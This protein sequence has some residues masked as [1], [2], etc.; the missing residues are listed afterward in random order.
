L[1][2]FLWVAPAQCSIDAGD[3][4]DVASN[5]NTGGCFGNRTPVALPAPSTD[6]GDIT[7]D[8]D[9]SALL[10]V[11]LPI[12]T[13]V[14]TWSGGGAEDLIAVT[15]VA[16]PPPAPYDLEQSFGGEV[17]ANG[18]YINGD[19][20]SLGARVHSPAGRGFFLEFEVVP[21]SSAFSHPQSLDPDA[22]Q[23]FR[24]ASSIAAAPQSLSVTMK[25]PYGAYR[26]AVRGLDQLGLAGPWILYDNIAPNFRFN[27]APVLT[28]GTMTVEQA[29]PAGTVVTIPCVCRD[30]NTASDALQIRYAHPFGT[31]NPGLYGA[32]TH[33][34]QVSC[35]DAHGSVTRIDSVVIV[36][37]TI[38]PTI[39]TVAM[40]APVECDTVGGRRADTLALTLPVVGDAADAD[41]TVTDDRPGVVLLGTSTL[42]QTVTD[43]GGNSASATLAVQVVD[44]EPPSLRAGDPMEVA[45]TYDC[46]AFH[47]RITLPMPEVTDVCDA[48]PQLRQ[49]VDG[50]DAP[51]V[52]LGDGAHTVTWTAVDAS[53]NAVTAQVA[54][55]VAAMNRPLPPADLKQLHDG[56][57]V[58]PGGHVPVYAIDLA[59]G[60]R[61]P[62][63]AT[64]YLLQV[65]VRTLD[66]PL[67]RPVSLQVDQRVYFESV[68]SDDDLPRALG[69]HVSGLP[70]GAYH[71]AVRAVDERGQVTDWVEFGDLGADFVIDSAAQNDPPVVACQDVTAAWPE[72]VGATVLLSCSCSDDW[73]PAP[74]LSFDNGNNNANP[75]LYP[76]GVTMVWVSCTDG[77]GR[78]GNT[79]AAVLVRDETPPSVEAGAD[80]GPVEC[81]GMRT[82]V[83]PNSPMVHDVIDRAPTYRFDA[84][85]DF[86]LGATTVTVT[87]TD[88]AGNKA[89]DTFQVH[90]ADRTAPIVAPGE[91][92]WVASAPGT[93]DCPAGKTP[94]LLATPVVADLCDG[95]PIIVNDQSASSNPSLC[96]PDGH[97]TVTWTATDHSG[98]NRSVAV[99]AT[100]RTPTLG[101]AVVPGESTTG[102]AEDL[103]RYRAAVV[104]PVPGVY[105]WSVEGASAERCLNE[106]CSSFV[107]EFAAEGIYCPWPVTVTKGTEY[108]REILC[109]GV[110]ATAP[111]LTLPAVRRTPLGPG[112]DV[113]F[114]S[115]DATSG[116]KS[117]VVQLLADTP[118]E[119]LRLAP[120]PETTG[121]LKR[122]PLVLERSGC[123]HP[124]LCAGG[125][126]QTFSLPATDV[127]LEIAVTDFAGNV[128]VGGAGFSLVDF[129]AGL[130]AVSAAA[131]QLLCA[132]PALVSATRSGCQ[133]PVVECAPQACALAPG[134]AYKDTLAAQ[135]RIDQARRLW[136]DD[137]P[138]A[139]LLAAEGEAS[140]G[141]ALGEGAPVEALLTE[142]QGL[143]AAEASRWRAMMRHHHG[144]AKWHLAG[145][146]ITAESATGLLWT[147][148]VRTA[149]TGDGVRVLE[150]PGCAG[151]AEDVFGSP[152]ACLVQ[153]VYGMLRR[154]ESEPYWA[155]GPKQ[156]LGSLTAT[157]AS[158]SLGIDDSALADRREWMERALLPAMAAYAQLRDLRYATDAAKLGLGAALVTL[159]E[160]LAPRRC[161]LTDFADALSAGRT[162]PV[163]ALRCAA[164]NAYNV[165]GACIDA[166][167]YGCSSAC[168]ASAVSCE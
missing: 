88:A 120:T 125:L 72:P 19:E 110:D 157:L 109:F 128:T 165:G 28:C 144:D 57:P 160:A 1:A 47:S 159:A 42:L 69:A 113:G 104:E 111:A 26:W 164:L 91:G 84:P 38:A 140:L 162:P 145:V 129:Y 6:C 122:G 75:D 40:S 71:W 107:A 45:A 97:T 41:L 114:A 44:T 77:H 85:A 34:A 93:G 81:T 33:T 66:D 87:A 16:A 149:L 83:V 64:R 22:V 150:S 14:V 106:G 101:L 55:T 56:T 90:V 79:S 118:I 115:A 61:H 37:D 151:R 133:A 73:S 153:G 21:A 60:S 27:S 9:E 154:Q 163:H 48:G 124:E 68:Q 80:V 146:A 63:A 123:T 92:R 58:D 136:P 7:Q 49:S 98:N 89:A 121:D 137:P 152:P 143:R 52:C 167:V 3:D 141:D 119:L 105:T 78:S 10:Q 166:T 161:A 43:D 70:N 31:G 100:V 131:A 2:F 32:G 112:V 12:G 116:V 36:R 117:V 23:F 50:S 155:A 147:E 168:G 67:Q 25:L 148:A 86:P 127:A 59:A 96:L 51:V 126:L 135:C 8:V 13:T 74:S 17:V 99:V 102:W 24:S 82:N 142:V 29:E 11:C 30:E 4:F 18:S 54:V 15:V 62:I 103:G 94:L 46:D 65:E 35:E 76:G 138:L 134:D 156:R 53:G 95:A 139:V 39:E 108:A 5:F 130:E 20:V 132:C 158:V